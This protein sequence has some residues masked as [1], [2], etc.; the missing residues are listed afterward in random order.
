MLF[1]TCLYL[2]VSTGSFDLHVYTDKGCE[3]PVEW[4]ETQPCFIKNAQELALRTFSTSLHKVETC[5]IYKAEW[6]G[7]LYYGTSSEI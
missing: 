7:I 6:S 2:L 1:L 5:V 3:V 4:D